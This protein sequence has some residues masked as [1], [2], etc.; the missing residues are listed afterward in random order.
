MNLFNWIFNQISETPFRS[1]LLYDICILVAMFSIPNLTCPRV[2]KFGIWSHAELVE[3][4]RTTVDHH[5]Q[6]DGF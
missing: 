6:R 4:A 1:E 3:V 5:S 2:L